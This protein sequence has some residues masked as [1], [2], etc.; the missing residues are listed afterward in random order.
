MMCWQPKTHAVLLPGRR[1]NVLQSE[2]FLSASSGTGELIT[3]LLSNDGGT[4]GHGTFAFL[5]RGPRSTT[6]NAHA[7]SPNEPTQQ[8]FLILCRETDS[9]CFR[10]GGGECAIVPH[11]IEQP[12]A[13]GKPVPPRAQTMQVPQ[14]R[15]VFASIQ[16][17]RRVAL[18]A[19]V[20]LQ[21]VDAATTLLLSRFL[22]EFIEV[23]G[24]K[25]K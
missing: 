24:S 1:L 13:S 8:L 7:V 17:A 16:H 25:V 22:G 4:G 21:T 15:A 9:S 14:A 3:D 11:Q 20:P 2:R 12:T 6:Q 23:F 19:T 5:A 10:W 18:R